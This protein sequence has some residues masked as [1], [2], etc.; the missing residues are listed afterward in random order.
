MLTQRLGSATQK[1]PAF[2]DSLIAEIKA[3]PGCCDEVWLATDYGFPP[4]DVHRAS[5]E[6]LKD[7]AEKFRAIG[8]RVS[9]QLS[10]SI[11]HGQY[12]SALDCSGLVY[13]G[14]PVE[15]MVGQGGEVAGYTFCWHGENFRRYVIEQLQ[16]YVS[17]IRAQYHADSKTQVNRLCH[18]AMQLCIISRAERL[19]NQN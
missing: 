5:A 18:K 3:H 6:T 15:H 4:M 1:N 12:M 11:G 2:I 10:N 9:L 8:V 17:A 14:S 16:A 19:R 13:E 7:V